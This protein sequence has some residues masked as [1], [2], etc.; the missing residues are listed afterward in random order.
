MA[1]HLER[2]CAAAQII[3]NVAKDAQS[4]GINRRKRLLETEAVRQAVIQRKIHDTTLEKARYKRRVSE[5]IKK[6]YAAFLKAHREKTKSGRLSN[7]ERE[8]LVTAYWDDLLQQ[9]LSGDIPES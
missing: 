8:E 5:Q 6:E 7:E 1:S 2:G 9:F 4:R 3:G